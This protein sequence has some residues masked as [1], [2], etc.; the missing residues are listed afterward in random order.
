ME[1]LRLDPLSPCFKEVTVV[2]TISEPTSKGCKRAGLIALALLVCGQAAVAGGT[3]AGDVTGQR[4]QAD[5]SVG[6]NWMMYGRTYNEQRFSPLKQIN[7]DNVRR[8]GVA[9]SIRPPS[10]DGLSTTPIVVDGV[11]Y[12]S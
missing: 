10:P 4:M 11:I 5:A 3:T 12:M 6:S 2:M 1:T 7:A 8:L 9:W